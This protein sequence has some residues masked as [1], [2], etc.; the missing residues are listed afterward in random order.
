METAKTRKVRACEAKKF[1]KN[2][3]T[4][5]LE[6][7]ASPNVTRSTAH[8]HVLKKR[9]ATCGH[10]T[11]PPT[12]ER[13]SQNHVLQQKMDYSSRFVRDILTQGLHACAF[14]DVFQVGRPTVL[15]RHEKAQRI[16]D[17]VTLRITF[18]KTSP[19]TSFGNLGR[20]R[21]SAARAF[22]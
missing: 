19:G 15:E 13:F 2:S 18:F 1:I 11:V 21:L 17:S 5:Q 4:T 7:C 12:A 3:P 6:M 20:T 14:H 16:D 9:L 22:P 8:R 10:G